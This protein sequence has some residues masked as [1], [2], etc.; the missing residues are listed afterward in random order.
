[1]CICCIKAVPVLYRTLYICMQSINDD[2]TYLQ[3][4][5][6]VKVK[7]EYQQNEPGA[8]ST[9]AVTAPPVDIHNNEE[10]CE[11]IESDYISTKGILAHSMDYKRQMRA[12][13]AEAV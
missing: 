8:P 9:D 2:T 13:I 11:C 7:A 4:N 3:I 12:M 5:T 6:F 10:K 1:M